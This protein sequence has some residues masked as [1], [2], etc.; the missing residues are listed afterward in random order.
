MS[1]LA[2]Q[3]R[4][5][6]DRLY[7][8]TPAGDGLAVHRRNLLA[9]L[10]G[11]LAATYPVV[12]RLVGEAFFGEAAR[13]HALANPSA[14]GDLNDYGAGFAAFL[15]TYEPARTLDYLPDVARLEWACHESGQAAE[16]A[17]L[18]FAALAL[19]DPDSQARIR[20]HLRPAVRLVR[21]VH[22]VASVWHANQPAN[23]GTPVRTEGAEHVLV[24]RDEGTV[25]VEVVDAQR[26]A[27]AQA[28]GRGLAL[29]E[30][31]APAGEALPAMLASLVAC[32]VIA[33]FT[34]P[35]SSP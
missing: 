11:A 14:S 1:T 26:W 21:S 20:F 8:E 10:G 27:F 35:H 32:G 9:N 30:A 24:R 28:I 16:A 22:P 13:R 17:G 15:E 19:V 3:Q 31:G 18:D 25:I 4:E 34:A 29:D 12:Q 5:F 7:A 6:I 23:D 2:A 33:G